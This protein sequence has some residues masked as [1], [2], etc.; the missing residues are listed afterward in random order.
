M[1]KLEIPSNLKARLS[2]QKINISKHKKRYILFYSLLCGFCH[3]SFDLF[4]DE[5]KDI[6]ECLKRIEFLSRKELGC[7][8]YHIDKPNLVRVIASIESFHD[9]NIQGKTYISAFMFYQAVIDD[10]ITSKQIM[11]ENRLARLHE[12]HGLVESVAQM[13]Q[14]I[15]EAEINYSDEEYAR[16]CD[17]ALKIIEAFYKTFEKVKK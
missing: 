10:L 17:N 8:K 6:F 15:F 16:D 5:S 3:T 2:N 13:I 1:K 4:E 9:T 11:S 14:I 7:L 12:L